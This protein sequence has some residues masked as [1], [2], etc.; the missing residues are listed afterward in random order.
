MTY[1]ECINKVRE[2]SEKFYNS[3]DFAHNMEHG[4]RVVKNAKMIAE[5][6]GGNLFLIEVGAWLHQ[7]HD[8]IIEVNN[9]IKTLDIE[10]EL[11]N[12]LYEIVKCRPEYISDESFFGKQ[13]CI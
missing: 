13:N 3:L 1:E 4:K 8:N 10:D 5:Q 9:F 11:K 2:F 12:Q 6:E 7:F